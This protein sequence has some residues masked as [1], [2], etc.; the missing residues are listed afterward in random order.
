MAARR[1]FCE[2]PVPCM[3]LLMIDANK[4]KITLSEQELSSYSL[5]CDSIDYDNTETRRAFWSILD[6]AKHRTGFDAA[7]DKIYI[8]VYPARDGGCEMFVTKLKSAGRPAVAVRQERLPESLLFR[9]AALR[10]MLAASAALSAAGYVLPSSAYEADGRYY[11]FL[12]VPAA[13]TVAPP[14][15]L[16]AAQK[17]DALSPLPPMLP[18]PE[19]PAW[20][21]QEPKPSV[22]PGLAD[23]LGEFG[24]SVDIAALPFLKEHADCICESRAMEIYASLASL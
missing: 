6:E 4:L 21:Y 12:T 15:T 17:A 24:E 13:G 14:A 7:S 18:L 23:L 3:E 20:G 2:R 11:L 8:Q 1:L 9:F 5:T 16:P 22:L 10:D 19:K